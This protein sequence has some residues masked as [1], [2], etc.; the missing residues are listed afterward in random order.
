[1]KKILIPTDGSALADYAYD[2]AHRIAKKTGAEIYALS[3]VTAPSGV[4]FDHDGNMKTDGAEDLSALV[5]QQKEAQ[6]A[7]EKWVLNKPDVKIAKAKIGHINQNILQYIKEEAV[8]LVVMGTTGASGLEEWIHG[9][10]A[11]VIVRNAPVPVLS[12]KC[13]RSGDPIKDIVLLSDFRRKKEMDLTSVKIL[14]KVFDAN[15]HLLKV[16]TLQDFESHHQ[17]ESDM[18]EFTKL[19]QLGNVK[20]HVYCDDTIEKGILNFSTDTGMDFI[21]IG[22]NQRKGFSRLFKQSISEGL[23][24]H[25]WQPI[26]TFP[27]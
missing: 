15:L 9:S 18:K 10:H 22:T 16:N 27:I 8:D 26:L 3:V 19:Q 4:L 14:Q 24:N 23:V 20:F 7:L 17:V 6:S 2:I 12:L 13:D 25:L 11:E 1:M 5:S 21:A